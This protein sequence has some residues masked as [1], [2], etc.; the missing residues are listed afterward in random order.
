MALQGGIGILHHNCDADEQ[1][2]MVHRVKKFEQGFIL[3]PVCL[4]PS[5]TVKDVFDVKNRL[6]FMGVPITNTGKLGGKLIGE[7]QSKLSNEQRL[8]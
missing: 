6:G 1:A 7:C 3:D 4:E 8:I 2:E 5:N